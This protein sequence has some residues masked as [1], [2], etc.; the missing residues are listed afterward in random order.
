[1]R[2]SNNIA[3]SG[4]SFSPFLSFSVL[5]VGSCSRWLAPHRDSY[6]FQA[7]IHSEVTSGRRNT[8]FQLLW[9]RP[10]TESLGIILSHWAFPEPN[11]V[12]KRS[13]LSI[14]NP[15]S[16]ET[17]VGSNQMKV[18]M[19]WL[20]EGKMRCCDREEE[21]QIL[22]RQ[23]PQT[24]HSPWKLPVFSCSKQ[25]GLPG[26]LPPQQGVPPVRTHCHCVLQISRSPKRAWAPHFLPATAQLKLVTPWAPSE[27]YQRP[28]VQGP[29]TFLSAKVFCPKNFR[30]H[31]FLK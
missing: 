9:Q 4:M 20:A 7:S 18:E 19:G 17:K 21:E 2:G 22:G 15:W 28:A 27:A 10:R 23:R 11:T 3:D 31:S 25:T 12:M 6:K 5:W 24:I 8:S 16:Q 30:H 14:A 26:L 1:M 13:G 29:V